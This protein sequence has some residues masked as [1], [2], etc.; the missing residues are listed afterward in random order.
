MYQAFFGLSQMPFDAVADPSFRLETAGQRG[1]VD[2]I[3][4]LVR[5]RS[6]VI[7]LE[8]WPGAGKTELLHAYERGIDPDRVCVRSLLQPDFDRPT[9]LAILGEMLVGPF[10]PAPSF[11][12]LQNLLAAR[13]GSGQATVLLVD[14]AED[15]TD[16]ALLALGPIADLATDERSLVSIVLAVRPPFVGLFSRPA[17]AALDRRASVRVR[18]PLLTPVEAR[19]L[20]EH[21]LRQ[22]GAADPHEVLSTEAI[23]ALVVEGGGIPRRLLSLGDRALQA[24]FAQRRLPVDYATVEMAIHGGAAPGAAPSRVRP[25]ISVEPGGF[26]GFGTARQGP[27]DPRPADTASR[28]AVPAMLLIV[29]LGLG[30]YLWN[31]SDETVSPPAP[32]AAATPP[33]PVPTPSLPAEPSPVVAAAPPSPPAAPSPPPVVPAPAAPRPGPVESPV[34]VLFIPASPGD[35]LRKLYGSAY[36]TPRYRPSFD[37]VLAANPGLEAD[38]PLTAGALVAL[39]GPLIDR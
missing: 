35:T 18:L 3:A 20:I 24:G 27:V 11:L 15:L 39:P 23:E 22:A 4:D 12:D 9:L 19:L 32:L 37:Q 13:D 10:A 33:M 6:G 1:A 30:Y 14:N 2:A 7:T 31:Q 8:G 17:A 38:Q 28:M 36:H 16:G 21:R 29:A 26:A 25:P 5:R 34:N